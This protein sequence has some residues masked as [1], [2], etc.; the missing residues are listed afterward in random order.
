MTDQLTILSEYPWWVWVF[1]LMVIGIISTGVYLFWYHVIKYP[2][3][4]KPKK[5]INGKRN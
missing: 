2:N 1:V 4:V 5:R 3:G